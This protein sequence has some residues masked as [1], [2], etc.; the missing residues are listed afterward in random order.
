MACRVILTVDDTRVV[1]KLQ[2]MNVNKRR[3]YVLQEFKLPIRIL[4]ATVQTEG[5]RRPSLS[6]K[7][8]KPLPKRLLRKCMLILSGVKTKPG[9]HRGDVLI[10]NILDTGVDIVCTKEL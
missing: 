3:S 6:V 5:C 4:T 8:S 1:K 10:K 2:G 7:S 9:L